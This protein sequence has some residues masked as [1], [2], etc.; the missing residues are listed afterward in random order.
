MAP[1]RC[2]KNAFAICSSNAIVIC[3][4]LCATLAPPTTPRIGLPNNEPTNPP[5]LTA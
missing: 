5:S 2:L 3:L 4:V 1:R